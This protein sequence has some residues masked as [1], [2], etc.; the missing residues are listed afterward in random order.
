[1]PRFFFETRVFARVMSRVRT[2]VRPQNVAGE[3]P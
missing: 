1:M 3:N 2:S